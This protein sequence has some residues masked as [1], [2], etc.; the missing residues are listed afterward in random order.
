MSVPYSNG[1]FVAPRAHGSLSSW[2]DYPVHQVAETIRHSQSSDRNFYDRYYFNC[3]ANDGEACLIMGLGQYPNLGVQDSFAVV[4][5][6]DDHRVIRA[7]REL[8]DRME[9]QVGPLRV[10][11]VRPLEELR[12]VCEPNEHGVSFDLTCV[13]AMPA[14]E[15]PRQYVR[16]HGRVVFDTMRL[17]QT[18]RWSGTI[19][20][21]DTTYE[22]TPDRW[23]GTRDRSWGVRP[24]GE[25]EPAG[26]RTEGQM[27][28]FWNYVPMQFEDHSIL[29][30]VNELPDGSRVLEEATRIWH[31]P[32][33]TPEHLGRPEHEAVITPGTRHIESST[34]RF[35]DAPE[36][37]FS[38]QVTPVTD[39]WLML[40]TGY[41]LEEDW[42]HGMYQGKLIV[43]GQQVNYTTDSERLFGL[44]DQAARFE[45]S[46]GVVGYGLH[47]FFFIGE[48]PRY[49]LEGWDP[50]PA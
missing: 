31:D 17:A 45:Q 34:L 10:E 32:D 24:V 5:A 12:I 11:V 44:V 39:V 15:E 25:Q 36:G 38:I 28:G 8:G 14:F 33:R 41:G 21:G 7:S 4:V 13:G 43:Q 1:G 29:Y 2:D 3:L 22:V 19:M 46:N 48:F 40:G 26:I 50:L 23:W 27:V 9:N 37:E 20:S 6:G 42:R 49:G 16:S 47:E 30:M 35:P 18:I